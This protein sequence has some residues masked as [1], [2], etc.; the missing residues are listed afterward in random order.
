MKEILAG[1]I[2]D[3]IERLQSSGKW[4]GFTVPTITVEYPKNEAFG[5]YTTNVAMTLAKPL[6]RNPMEVA[7]EIAESLHDSFA[8][9]TEIEKVEVVRPGYLNFYLS[10]EYFKNLLGRIN[11]EGFIFGKQTEKVMVEY[12]QPNTHK[13]FHIGHLRNVFIGSALVNV[14]RKAGYETIA[15]NYFGD[16]GTHIAKCLWGLK[17]FHRNEDFDAI[18]DKAEFLGRVYSEASQKIEENPGFEDEFKALQK[19]FEEG[20]SELVELWEKTKRWSLDEFE[21]LYAQLGV[22]FDVCFYESVEEASGKILLPELLRKN[23]VERSED[24]IIANLEPY[25]LGVLVLVR[26]D[27][28]ALYGLKDIPLAKKKFE[29]YGIDRSV[30]VVDV[31]QGLYFQQLFKILELYGFH[32]DMAHVDYEFVALKGGES[33][34]SRK[35]NIISARFLIEQVTEKV[36]KQFPESPDPESIAIGAIRFGMLKHSSASRIEFDIDES[37]K[38]EGATGP[39]VQYASARMASIFRKAEELDIRMR[40]GMSLTWQLHEKEI[41]LI[42]EL[43]KFPGLIEEVAKSYEIHKLSHYVL[44][45]ADKFHS[46]YNDCKV[47][48]LENKELSQARL[49]LVQATRIVLS[50]T[51]RLIGVSAPERM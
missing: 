19:K 16:T 7:N 22:K 29:E 43:E 24:A 14:L 31:R 20:D 3:A 23:V 10:Q 41:C 13:E 25:K 1:K 48:D 42:R 6:G 30:Y 51:L 4:L 32:K 27:G 47:L 8:Q 9:N 37:V 35:G 15:A 12:S 5:D 17:T 18:A 33:M 2:K 49:A 38:L 28:S 11:G 21:R 45:V 36:K 40:D 34:S 26:G 39:Y 50:E 46:F 44:K